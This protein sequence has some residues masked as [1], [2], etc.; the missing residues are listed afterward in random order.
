MNAAPTIVV[1]RRYRGPRSSGNGGYTSGLVASH[2][3]ADTVEVTLRAPP[4]PADHPFP[5]CFTCV[6]AF[7]VNPEFSRGVSVLGRLT[8]HVAS[9]PEAGDECVVVAWPLGGEGRRLFAGTAVFRGS[10]ALAWARAVWVTVGP[11][12]RDPVR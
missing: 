9:V 11:E 5:G 12:L 3:D 1:A 2:V 10:E 8:A 6:P 4:P 7:A